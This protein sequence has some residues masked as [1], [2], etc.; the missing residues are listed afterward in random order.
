MDGRAARNRCALLFD[1]AER[2]DG[3]ADRAAALDSGACAARPC[4]I[5]RSRCGAHD[6][7]LRSLPAEFRAAAHGV[8]LRYRRR[9]HGGGGAA[10]HRASHAAGAGADRSAAGRG[11]SPRFGT[12]LL[13]GVGSR[14][15]PGGPAAATRTAVADRP[16]SAGDRRSDS[17]GCGAEHGGVG[18]HREIDQC[19]AAFGGRGRHA[20]AGS[21]RARR[22]DPVAQTER[23]R[24]GSR[25][26]REA[27]R[28][29]WG[30]RAR[31][32][33]CR[34]AP[35]RADRWRRKSRPRACPRRRRDA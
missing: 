16:R 5:R 26:R 15:D 31:R 10:A 11:G 2:L 19:G 32:R 23:V 20:G 8:H 24:R 1:L 3:I 28:Q 9:D 7:H 29:N 17:L 6:D 21:L 25:A 33:G 18:P 34:E 13:T 27:R 22:G 12:A 4:T 35:R 14:H 30:C